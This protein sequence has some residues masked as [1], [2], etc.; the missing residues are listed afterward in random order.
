[1]TTETTRLPALQKTLDQIEAAILDVS[2]LES[3]ARSA[4]A[5]IFTAMRNEIGKKSAE[6]PAR[7]P[8]CDLLEQAAS[9][10]RQGGKRAG[11]IADAL[12]DLDASLSWYRRTDRSN[13]PEFL[14]GHANA[15]LVG[16]KGVE[17]RDDVWIGVSLMAPN[18]TYPDHHHPPEEVYV[19]LSDGWWRQNDNA[20]IRPGI[21]GVVYNPPDIIHAMKS[22]DTPLLA[23]WCLWLGQ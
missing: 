20:W 3:P 19:V 18:L 23:A 13:A 17:E 2:K 1:M 8:A 9:H 11:A 12:L 6:P 22:A 5:R 14:A 15:V 16:P 10:A 7:A 21:G 4:A